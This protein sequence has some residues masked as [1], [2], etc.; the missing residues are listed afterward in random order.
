MLAAPARD[1]LLCLGS[2]VQYPGPSRTVIREG[3]DSRFVVIILDGVVKV[4]GH[5]LSGREVLLAIRMAGDLVG[6]FAALDEKPRSATVTTCGAMAARVIK[7][8]DFLGCLRRDPEIA[9]AVQQSV[10][11]KLR[12]ANARRLDFSGCDVPTR[13]ARVLYE[14]ALTYG[15]RTGNQSVIRWPLT[16]PELASLA[17][18][19]EPTVQRVLRDL[20]ESAVVATGYR[21]I[22]ILDMDR[23]HC[24]AHAQ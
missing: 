9:H 19:A 10:V 14:L 6:E 12:T 17:G 20:R 5:V 22:T 7:Y 15:T 24:V 2:S 23:L 3:D 8:S 16:Q 13:I 21:A 11:A 18:S 1:R 4:T